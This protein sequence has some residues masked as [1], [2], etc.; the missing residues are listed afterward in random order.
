MLQ[1]YV[2]VINLGLLSLAKILRPSLLRCRGARI[3]GTVGLC[4]QCQ[5]G[6]AVPCLVDSL[7]IPSLGIWV[8]GVHVPAHAGIFAGCSRSI[9]VKTHADQ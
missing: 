6:G 8:P 5:R 9:N 7:D 1:S 4:G 3:S 2:A